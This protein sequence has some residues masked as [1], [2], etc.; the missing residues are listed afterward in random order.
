MKKTNIFTDVMQV[1]QP[2]FSV[3][4]PGAETEY[5]YTKIVG[6]TIYVVITGRQNSGSASSVG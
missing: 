4:P 1:G 5:W 3:D 2:Q 6:M